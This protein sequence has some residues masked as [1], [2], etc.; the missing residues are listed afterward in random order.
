MVAVHCGFILITENNLTILSI[1]Q[2][3]SCRDLKS[4]VEKKIKYIV[5]LQL[6]IVMLYKKCGSLRSPTP[7]LCMHFIC[8]YTAWKVIAGPTL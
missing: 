8:L 2:S 4:L 3:E 5:M 7:C 6:C 1:G